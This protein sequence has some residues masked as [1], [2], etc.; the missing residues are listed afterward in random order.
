MEAQKLLAFRDPPHKF[1][2]ISCTV[3]LYIFINRQ[4][5]NVC[6]N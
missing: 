4:Q 3:D 1:P 6:E 2:A 5:S